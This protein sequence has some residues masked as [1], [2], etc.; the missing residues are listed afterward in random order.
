MANLP[1]QHPNLSV[2]LTDRALT[3]LITSS[4]SSHKL[5][6][7]SSLSHTALV[8]HESALRLGLGNPQRIMVEYA[9]NGPVLLHSFL[10]PTSPCQLLANGQGD[11]ATEKG[12]QGQTAGED[13]PTLRGEASTSTTPRQQDEPGAIEGNSNAPPMLL[14]TV[15]APTAEHT[16]ESRRAAARLE[17]VGRE[18]QAKWAEASQRD[19]FTAGD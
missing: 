10:I 6:S 5:Q 13:E 9:S 18:V 16:L 17:R 8:A 11:L 7:L 19:E 3:P 2:H 1:S 15:L 4:R 14:S 12:I